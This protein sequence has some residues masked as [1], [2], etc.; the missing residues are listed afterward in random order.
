MNWLTKIFSQEESAAP[1]KASSDLSPTTTPNTLFASS[2]PITVSTEKQALATLKKF[3]PIR[4][5]DDASV[6][7]LAHSTLTYAAESVIF[8]LGQ[9]TPSVFYLLKGCIELQPDCD[10]SYTL[11]DDSTLA[12][13]P[14]NSGKVCGA[15][16]IAKTEV[17]IVS[18]ARE[19]IQLWAD[20]S[21]EKEVQ[22]DLNSIKLP[23]AIAESRFFLSFSEAYKE[24]RL[25]L[26]S[27]PNVAFKLKEAINKDVGIEG[28]VK[29][30]QIDAPIV[31]K[32]IQVANSAL[33]AP[34]SPLTNCQDAVTRLG[35][36]AT[37]NLVMGISLKQLFNCKDPALMKKMQQLWKQSLHVSCLSFVLA[38]ESGE[39]KPE[40]ALLAGLICDIGAIPV[41]N[42]AMQHPQDYADL[43]ELD[44]ALPYLSPAAGSLVLRTLGFSEELSNL[45]RQASDWFYESGG[46]HLTLIDV[47]I[48]AKLHS[49][50]GTPRAK[51]LPYINS[52]PAYT[53]LKNG[54]LNPD[55]SLDVLHKAQQR[56]NAAMSIFS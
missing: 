52:I 53:K 28:A 11:S 36:Y 18:I 3:A 43:D 17:V 26:P 33:Y 5:L 1:A 21:R 50:I 49:Y 31:A 55:F 20:K 9:K 16:A 12:N 35:L 23:A 54:K 15:T 44:T 8:S 47:V 41:L 19:L 40:D 32:L 7:Q 6:N 25:S 14:L 10:N 46:D 24:N 51:G 13:L 4:D 30:I 37:R 56:I 42:F 45:P 34:I 2:E 39:V 29:I 27:L 22:S 38:D 48:L